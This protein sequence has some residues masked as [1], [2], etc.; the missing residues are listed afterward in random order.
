MKTL[1]F[2]I[3]NNKGSVAVELALLLPILIMILFATFEFGLAY[4]NYLAI[5][6]AAR[7]GAR[8]AA[9]GKYDESIVQER[10]YPVTPTS[11][12][13]SYPEGEEEGKP[14]KVTVSYD[15]PLEIPFFGSQT[16]PLSAQAEMRVEGDD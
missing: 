12:S 2:R 1:A 9:V 14:V 10:A 13:V 8:L 7:E 3:K 11:I 4:N 15:F 16:I 6:H 5:T